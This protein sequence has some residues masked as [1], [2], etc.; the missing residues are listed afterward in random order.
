[1]HTDPVVFTIF[2]IF[3][4]AA[5][6]ATLALY[7]RQA[8]LVAYI[9]LGMLL[10][11]SGIG[12]VQDP[13]VVQ[14]VAHIGIIF[15][16][17]LL[18]L[19]LYPQKLLGLFKQTTVVT[20]VSCLLFSGIGAALGWMFG[21]TWQESL[22]IGA[23][24]M[25]S[26][27]IIGL[28]LLPTTVLHHR[29]TGEII[30]SILLLQDIL[31]IMVLLGLQA[32]GHGGMPVT[33]IV[34]VLLSL[35][36]LILFA[37]LFERYVLITLIRRF[38]KIHEYIFLLAIGWCIGV[39]QLAAAMELSHEIG[40]FIA[41]VLLA[42]SPIALYIADSLRPLRDFFLV[43]FFFTLGARFDLTM[44]MDV[45]APAGLL[46]ALALILKPLVFQFL[47]HRSGEALGRAREVGLRLGQI[48]EFSLLIAVLAMNLDVIG[49]QASYLIQVGTLL[50]FIVSSYVIV[51][52][53]PTPIAISDRLRRD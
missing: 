10:G 40:A 3:T 8:M 49:E 26:S 45:L 48:S 6:L 33:E 32:R 52:C 43:M 46:A 9:V 19:D 5:G 44:L 2:L 39:A 51:M 14:Q 18:G 42:T 21:F 34:R 12:L 28:K 17:F 20:G 27:T 29:H 31:A 1:M 38:D 22:T 50:T 13:D 36:V 30:I 53:Y 4:G 7:S 35:P 24:M 41:G 15:L 47:L 37:W 16:L 23:A 11:P 25:F